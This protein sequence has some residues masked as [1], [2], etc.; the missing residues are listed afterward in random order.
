MKST[1]LLGTGWRG[2]SQLFNC[3][4][5]P[6]TGHPG[7]LED[8][9]SIKSGLLCS[10]KSATDQFSISRKK[11]IKIRWRLG[12]ENKYQRSFLGFYIVQP[13]FLQTW[14]SIRA[15]YPVLL[16]P[17]LAQFRSQNKL[18]QEARAEIRSFPVA[19]TSPNF[20][21]RTTSSDRSGGKGRN[22]IQ[23]SSCP[24]FFFLALEASFNKFQVS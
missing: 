1:K 21:T 13:G 16:N 24:V 19:Q 10:V 7:H 5:G 4:L 9:C 17:P 11:D 22:W 20:L 2:K 23:F 8:L 18:D 15:N 14:L 6:Y 3:D 12:E